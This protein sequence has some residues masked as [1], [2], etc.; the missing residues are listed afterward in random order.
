MQYGHR[1]R[2]ALDSEKGW[3]Y[4]RRPNGSRRLVCWMPCERRNS[5]TMASS[6]NLVCIGAA[7]GMVTILDFSDL[8]NECN[9]VDG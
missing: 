9:L 8:N 2:F 6:G 5:G 7:T 3:I 4:A 1:N